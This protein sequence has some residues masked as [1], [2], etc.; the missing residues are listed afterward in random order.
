MFKLKI[1]KD[2]AQEVA[3]YWTDHNVTLHKQF[4]SR[5]ESLDYFHW[6]CDQYSGYLDLMPVKGFDGKDILDY[7]C[8]P[9]HDLVGFLEYSKPKNLVGADVS[10]S[11][12]Q[13]AEARLALHDGDADLVLL[14]PDKVQ[15]PFADQSFDYI[16]SSGVLHHLPN[17][18]QTLNEF[19][20]IL[21]PGG[22]CRVMVYNYNSI[23]LHLYV[24]YSLRLKQKT[25]PTNLPI[26]QAFAH[27]TDGPDCPI[28]NC[29]T[30]EEFG[31]EAAKAGFT[32]RLLGAAYSELERQTLATD[33]YAAFMDQRFE[34]E[35]REFLLALTFDETGRALYHGIPAGVDLV[36][37][38]TLKG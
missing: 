31:E 15:L 29:Y 3:G 28:S 26:R 27:S 38:L 10:N 34:R 30:P 7:G 19:R 5:K 14:D 25:I 33:R 11:S 2:I 12:L 18:T 36:L 1:R 21:R 8:G 32:C 9:G 4:A 37:E 22:L 6:R 20:R 13:E 16:H 23:F 17:L 24:A 35:H